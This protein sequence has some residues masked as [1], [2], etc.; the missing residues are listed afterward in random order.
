MA[1]VLL[2]EFSVGDGSAVTVD[3][4]HTLVVIADLGSYRSVQAYKKSSVTTILVPSGLLFAL[5]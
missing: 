4:D 3:S 2:S 1:T 5:I